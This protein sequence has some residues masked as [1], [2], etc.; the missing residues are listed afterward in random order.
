MYAALLALLGLLTLA[1]GAAAD[2]PV[3]VRLAH[4][5]LAHTDSGAVALVEMVEAAGS[6]WPHD[7]VGIVDAVWSKDRSAVSRSTDEDL[8][9]EIERMLNTRLLVRLD[10]DD[11][12]AVLDEWRMAVAQHT[13]AP[14]VAA[15]VQSYTSMVSEN[16]PCSTWVYWQGRA[17][18]PADVPRIAFEAATA[19]PRVSDHEK[20]MPF[21]H[22]FG[23]S[24]APIAVLYADPTSQDTREVLASLFDISESV[25]LTI[26]LRWNIPKGEGGAH[27]TGAFGASLHLKK[28]DYLVIDDRSVNEGGAL[29]KLPPPQ[30]SDRE[31]LGKELG[32]RVKST[33]DAAQGAVKSQAALTTDQISLLGYGAARAIRKSSDPLRALVQ[34][35]SEFPLFAA[36]L[37][38]YAQG[39]KKGDKVYASFGKLREY[40]IKPGLCKVWIN[41]LPL[42]ID[43]FTPELLPS[44]IRKE[45]SLVEALTTPDIGFDHEGAIT[46][47]MYEQISMAYHGSGHVTQMYDASDRAEPGAIFYL[48]DVEAP[49]NTGRNWKRSL[50]ALHE[51]R[52][53]SGVLLARNLHNVI[54]IPDMTRGEAF[55]HLS[56][57]VRT[58]GGP[59]VI[60]CGVVPMGSDEASVAL[61]H[62]LDKLEPIDAA[63]L[64][65][66]TAK[67]P[68][69]L[70]KEL[71]KVLPVGQRS[72]ELDAFLKRGTIGKHDSERL[73]HMRGYL[74]RLN[75][76]PSEA[77]GTVFID[78]LMLPFTEQVFA[79]AGMILAQQETLV[80]DYMEDGKLSDTDDVSNF[81]YDLPT[82]MHA[83]S[84]LNVPRGSTGDIK[85]TAVDLIQAMH[86]CTVPDAAHVLHDFVYNADIADVSIRVIADIDSES[87]RFLAAAVL[88]ALRETSTGFRVGFVHTGHSGAFSR[89]I[90]SAGA[91][92]ALERIS[93][94]ELLSVIHNEASPEAV[95]DAGGFTLKSA[96]DTDVFWS[97]V[98]PQFV[99]AAHLDGPALIANGIALSFDPMR[100]TWRDIVALVEVEQQIH[101]SILAQSVDLGGLERPQ[102]SLSLEL[103]GAVLAVATQPDPE[104]EGIFFGESQIRSR[105]PAELAK[106]RAAFRVNPNDADTSVRFTVVMDPLADYAPL[107]ASTIHMLST[108]R[109][110]SIDVVM[111]PLPKLGALP[112]QRFVRYDMHT[113]PI[114]KDGARVAPTVSFGALPQSAVLTMEMHAPRGMVAMADRAVYDLDNIRLADVPDRSRSYGV[115]ALYMAHDLLIEGHGREVDGSSSRGIE[116]ELERP[117]SEEHHDTIQMENLGYFQFRVPPGRWNLGIRHGESSSAYSLASVGANGWDSPPVSVTGRAVSVDTL[118]GNVVYPRFTARETPGSGKSSTPV[119]R[120]RHADINIFTVASGHLYE[121][122]VYIMVLSVLRHTKRSVKFWFIENFLSPAFKEFIPHLAETYEFEYEMVTYAWPRW[123]RAQTEKQRMI[124]AYKILFLDVLF[125]LDLDRVIFV[126]ADQIVRHDL[127]DLIKMDLGDAP[128]GYPPMGD[129]SEDMEGFRFWK[130]GY[131]AKFLRGRTY[132]IS[133]LYVVDLQTFREMGAGDILRKHYQQLSADP[134][135]LANLDQDLPNHREFMLTPCNTSCLSSLLTR[136]GSGARPGA[137]TTGSQRRRLSTSAATPRRRSPSLIGLAVRSRSGTNSTQRLLRL[138]A[139]LRVRLHLVRERVADPQWYMM[140][141]RIAKIH[142][143]SR[144]STLLGADHNTRKALDR[145]GDR[146]RW[147]IH[148][149]NH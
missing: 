24:G 14:R 6:L 26:V 137:P 98:G 21:D 129:D 66:R 130:K 87:G 147:R 142:F 88:R 96:Q 43:Q 13:Y 133:A 95:A 57:M 31:W 84:K 124:W 136:H 72:P 32:S 118:K 102:R 117:D 145:R 91:A 110:V 20:T 120:R 41:G 61:W 140:S 11:A 79:P 39:V 60:R 2:T 69:M 28:V 77:Y 109:G 70:R 132:H 101:A 71:D 54:L 50:N 103:M 90:Y 105:I 38:K 80:L 19:R 63:E 81:F 59:Q 94:D 64:L 47:L 141:S 113:R 128:Y 3:H 56:V 139:K 8:Y 121:R 122:M 30:R 89:L 46:M 144:I 33:A 108:L 82:T 100:V 99:R 112:L 67:R 73:A 119:S 116:L 52:M 40:D 29:F 22:V 146:R 75:I 76:S 16:P 62:A 65:Q 5:W 42:A 7:F 34:L 49:D 10:A 138:R 78:G 148:R 83:R 114:F 74:E 37:S 15:F 115:E 51:R 25:A 18:C 9:G 123:L 92:R 12:H 23:R 35:T 48:N 68:E 127:Y 104:T 111:N 45:R 131:W 58:F 17:L 4:P 86:A 134:N 1:L 44:H 97:N 107:F 27:Y 126:D 125:P 53:G 106:L 55:E 143:V 93:A 149:V 36:T 85:S 135:S